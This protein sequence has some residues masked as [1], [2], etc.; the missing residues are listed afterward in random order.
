MR[1]EKNYTSEIEIGASGGRN[2]HKMGCGVTVFPIHHP[3]LPL[4]DFTLFEPMLHN[5]ETTML[6]PTSVLILLLKLIAQQFLVF[7]SE[8]LL[9]SSYPQNFRVQ[10]LSDQIFMYPFFTIQ[11]KMNKNMNWWYMRLI[12]TLDTSVKFR[13]CSHLFRPYNYRNNH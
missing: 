5:T 9:C 10:R 11:K 2:V 6:T 4:I 12:H 1:C 13:N 7:F 3:I 8:A